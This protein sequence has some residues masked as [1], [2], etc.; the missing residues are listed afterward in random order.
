[1]KFGSVTLASI[2]QSKMDEL[3][4]TNISDFSFISIKQIIIKIFELDFHNIEVIFLMKPQFEIG[5]EKIDKTH[6]VVKDPRLY[7]KVTDDI[8]EFCKNNNVE[9]MG[10]C[11]S[12]I[13]GTKLNNNE[14]LIHLF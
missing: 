9:F 8:K 2:E 7:K 5:K 12:S 14:F 4:N 3:F 6:G 11:N 10:V 13:I 1:M